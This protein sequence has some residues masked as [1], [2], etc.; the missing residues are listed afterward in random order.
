LWNSKQKE[1]QMNIRVRAA[2]EVVGGFAGFALFA[3]AVMK[4]LD[5]IAEQYGQ[6]TAALAAMTLV[7]GSFAWLV[8]GVRVA[9]LKYQESLRNLQK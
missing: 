6:N 7:L 2:F 3:Y 8:Y 4:A 1:K 9:Q 5:F